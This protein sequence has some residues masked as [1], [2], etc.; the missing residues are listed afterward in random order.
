M[1]NGVF[2]KFGI[3]GAGCCGDP[4]STVVVLHFFWISNV[5]WSKEFSPDNI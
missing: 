4:E 1:I 3:Y 2:M 5:F